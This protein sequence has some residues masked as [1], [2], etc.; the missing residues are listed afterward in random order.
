MGS[1]RVR[2]RS[3]GQV[4]GAGLLL[5]AV[6]TAF[7]AWAITPAWFFF[8]DFFFIQKARG[9][10]SW[11]Y[12]VQPYNGHLMPAGW[13]LTWANV[14]AGPFDFTWPRVEIVAMFALAGLGV[15][16]A[17]TTLFGYRPAVLVLL[18]LVLFSPIL[19]P[20]T[21][22]WA[23][24][25]N[26]L[27]MLAAI[28]F[29][30]AWFVRYLRDHGTRDLLLSAL[31]LVVGLAFVERTLVGLLVMWLV[32]LLYFATG[33]VPER[34]RHLLVTYRRAVVVHGVCVIAYLAVYVPYAM[35]FDAASITRRPLFGVLANLAGKALPVGFAG[36]PL[37]W[38]QSDVTQQEA[39]PQQVV[40]ILGWL[41]LGTLIFLSVR[42]RRRGGRAWVVPGAVLLVNGVLIATSRAI[43]FGQEVALD[44]R[45]QTELALLMPLAIGLAFLPVPGAVECAE[46]SE[47]SSW[48][49]QRGPVATAVAVFLGATLVS[50]TSFPLRDLGS[51]SPDRY[52]ANFERSAREHRGV[53]V[54]DLPTPDYMWAE[55]AYPTNLA[56]R[57]LEPLSGLVDFESSVTDQAWR[58]DRAGRLVPLR[59]IEARRQA[60]PVGADGC[61]ATLTHA[62][63]S[64]FALDGPVVG[65]QWFT[66][67]AYQ[68]SS[69]TRLQITVN[70]VNR[71]TT[72]T[73]HLEPGRHNVVTPAPGEYTTVTVEVGSGA[74][75][76]CL[77]HLGVVSINT[78]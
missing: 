42:V 75:A 61:F 27:P 35:N 31:A 21:T 14:E 62:G 77:R 48:L 18:V 15:L 2:E 16:F 33:T 53:Q 44:Y 60:S 55:F 50:T 19:L 68:V 8:D 12:L 72:R 34:I 20:A 17:L 25:V 6:A 73:V 39:H 45:F 78:G 63:S 67:L 46:P 65:V 76:I 49:T 26:Q 9:G 1:V 23:A 22:W 69:R 47:G 38:H 37:R 7:R 74:P 41:V 66:R 71:A 57:M 40:L 28:S 30:L 13:L 29:G 64:V 3:R 58:I 56:S 4:L 52:V 32:A 70:D 10:L 54:I 43:F 5:V 11:S 51:S 59:V 36:G 24:A